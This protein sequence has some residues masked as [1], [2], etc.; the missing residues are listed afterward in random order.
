VKSYPQYTY[1]TKEERG[2]QHP[3]IAE[4]FIAELVAPQLEQ[5]WH[6]AL[7]HNI[8]ETMIV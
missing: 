8:S 7:I 1:S 2:D 5:V 4:K 3:Y 6:W